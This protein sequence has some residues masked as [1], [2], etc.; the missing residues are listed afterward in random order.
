MP[1]LMNVTK[2]L[3]AYS[4]P[5]NVREL[6]NVIERAIILGGPEIKFQEL[7][8][9]DIVDF[10]ENEPLK[11][12]DMEKIHILKS[13]KKTSGKIGGKDGA[14]T[15]LGVKRTTLINRMKKLGITV[16]RNAS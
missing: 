13:L 8:N 3:E 1:Q 7:E 16:E 12:K 10:S 5:G 15:L 9:E 2:K 4:W 14:S 6:A 11:L